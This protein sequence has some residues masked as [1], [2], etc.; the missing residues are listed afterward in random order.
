M[1]KRKGKKKRYFPDPLPFHSLVYVY[2]RIRKPHEKVK[3]VSLKSLSLGFDIKIENRMLYWK[4][5]FNM[6]G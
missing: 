5:G 1:Y 6:K 3:A 4:M 2:Q